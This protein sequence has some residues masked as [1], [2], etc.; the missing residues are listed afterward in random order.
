MD[1][2]PELIPGVVYSFESQERQYP[3]TGAPGLSYFEGHINNY[4]VV[5]CLLFRASDERV[6]GIL[7]HYPKDARNPNYGTALGLLFGEKEFI[8]RAGNINI[9]IHEDY[10]RMGI[11]TLLVNEAEVRWGP[12]NFQQQQYSAEGAEFIRGY[13][14]KRDTSGHNNTE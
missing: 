14:S 2:E 4:G 6:V 12:L 13:L 5:H 9:F 11:A 3:A 10:K 7:N 1:W 8:E